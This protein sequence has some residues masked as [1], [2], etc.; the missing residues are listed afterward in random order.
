VNTTPPE[1]DAP[2][3]HRVARNTAL[4]AAAEIIGKFATLALTVVMADRLGVAAVG[5][6]AVALAV[7]QL[8]WPI[9]GFGLDRLMLREIA[10]DRNATQRFV[11]IL[12]SFKLTVGLACTLAGTLA[13]AATRGWTQVTW[14]VVIL[15]FALVAGLIGTTAQSVF[16]AHER[17]QDYFLAALPVKLFAAVLGIAILLAGGGVLLVAVATLLAALAGIVIGWWI[18]GKRYG[19]RPTGLDRHP[20]RW[21]PILRIS[22]PWGLQE[23]FGQIT[24]RLGII[25]LYFTAGNVI[26]GQYRAAYQL[27]EA[28]LFLP[29]SIAASSL[30]LIARAQRGVSVGGE[31]PL[32]VTTRSSIEL[33]LALL[34]P[35]AVLLGLCPHEVIT[36]I[37]PNPAMAPAAE[38]LPYLAVA[39]VVYGIGHIAGV[40]ALSHLP[41]RRTIE[42]TALAA[43]FSVVAVIV[44]VPSQQGHGAAIASLCTELVLAVL[45]IRLAIQAAG[46]QFLLGLMS[47][48]TIAAACMVVAVLPFRDD[49][50]QAIVAGGSVYTAVLLLLEYRRQGA[51]WA[52]LRST[53]PGLR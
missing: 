19:Q 33:T 51:T 17:N 39:S 38:F 26:T 22:G 44:L 29:W 32:E 11:P 20:E 14:L 45:S 4:R 52:L 16:M 13:M 12:N 27:L 42:A 47:T 18:L 15:S 8:Y 30:P 41:G 31:P 25:V 28:T 23:V 53:I 2:P 37:Y 36:T 10:V 24:F 48:S 40:I 6:F 3:S 7:T 49:L 46:P 50:F 21:W 9:A 1:T 34:L 35:I 43:A 5:D